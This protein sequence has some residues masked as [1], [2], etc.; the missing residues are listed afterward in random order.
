MLCPPFN[1]LHHGFQE[2]YHTSMQK[3]VPAHRFNGQFPRKPRFASFPSDSQS[4]VLLI[5][6]GYNPHIFP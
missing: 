3:Y 2:V 1:Q 6:K 4:S 5:L